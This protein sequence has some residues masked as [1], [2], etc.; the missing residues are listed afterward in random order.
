MRADAAPLNVRRGRSGRPFVRL[1]RAVFATYTH[2]WLCG[3]VVDQ[4]LP[5][6]D[7]M[8]RSLDHVV[9]LVQGGDPLDPS[10]ARLAHRKCNSAKADGIVDPPARR[11]S[12][13]WL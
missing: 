5:V 4:S 12:R 11:P 9:P 8:A 13:V 7:R 10:N 2:C 6:N 1:Q 3:E